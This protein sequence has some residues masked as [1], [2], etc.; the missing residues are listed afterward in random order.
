M[1]LWAFILGVL[2]LIICNLSSRQSMITHLRTKAMYLLLS[3]G[4]KLTLPLHFNVLWFMYSCFFSTKVRGGGESHEICRPGFTLGMKIALSEMLYLKIGWNRMSLMLSS[5]VCHGEGKWAL[6]CFQFFY[7]FCFC[8][9]L[10]CLY[11]PTKWICYYLQGTEQFN[12]GFEKHRCSV[13][14]LSSSSGV[15]ISGDYRIKKSKSW[16]LFFLIIFFK[17]WSSY[18][19][20][21]SLEISGRS[22]E[23][24]ER[25]DKNHFFKINLQIKQECQREDEKGES[26][27]N[28]LS[29]HIV[30]LDV[31][32]RPITNL[33][34]GN[35]RT[36][37]FSQAFS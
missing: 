37:L 3:V 14:L 30:P 21:H 1:A 28:N 23:W 27:K 7:W 13:F 2:F 6:H 24:R 5:A 33:L 32:H 12:Y 25:A 10:L 17:R 26:V 29:L 31:R 16:R 35:G 36:Q 20:G 34:V 15:T 22:E 11:A 19:Q 8:L 9:T 18:L 4:S